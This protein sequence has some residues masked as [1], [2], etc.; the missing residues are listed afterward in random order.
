MK[1]NIINFFLLQ[2]L[3]FSL[4]AAE[5][6]AFSKIDPALLEGAS[7]VK[8]YELVRFE[9]KNAGSAVYYYKTATTIL[10]ENGDEYAGWQEGYDDKFTTIHS[11]NAT[12]YDASGKKIRSLKKAEIK[13]VSGTGGGTLAGD[14]R[15]KHHNFYY[16]IYPYTVEYEVEI[17]KDELMFMPSWTPVKNEG[18]AVENSTFE[19]VCPSGYQIRYK[20]FNYKK[21]P[22]VTGEKDKIY[23]WEV[24]NLPCVEKEFASPA[25]DE[26]TP[27]VYVAPTEFEVQGY[28]GIMNSWLN[29]GKFQSELNK[30]RDKLPEN[31]KTKVHELTDTVTD[32]K[33]KISI[34]YQYMQKNTRYISI[35][36]G[37]G[38][39]Q[40]LEASFVADKGYGDCK[41]LSNFMHS[42]LK[43]AGINSYYCL[44]KAGNNNNFYLPDFP[45]RQSNHA[46]VSV[47]LEKDTVWLECTS[48][49]LPAGYLSG[50]TSNRYALMI[51]D[52][53]GY[54]VHTP[55]YSYKDNLLIRKINATLDEGGNLV[56]DIATSYT[57]MQQDGLFN[58]INTYS[59]K[60]QLDFLKKDIELPSYDIKSF[61]YKT[62]LKQIPEIEE[63]LSVEAHDYAQVSGKRIFIQPNLL[64]KTALEFSD[65]ERINDIELKMGFSDQDSVA[66]KV[67]SGFAVEA[68]PSGVNLQN[69]FGQY[70]ISYK[71]EDN[72]IM[73]TRLFER[74]AGRFPA[75]DYKELLKMYGDMYKA[76]RG[77]IVL[78]KKDGIAAN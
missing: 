62:Y 54:L 48:Q 36:L 23:R 61:D 18:Y 14:G 1:K 29:F 68:L 69:K 10:N 56:A 30:N 35:Q 2:L 22:V 25:W 42:L 26:I 21:E 3:S 41:A 46:L 70:K 77:K 38:G 16:K 66:I 32:V 39:W 51:K 12:L 5:D 60:E 57:G 50:F 9:I 58:I 27:T 11:V 8:R 19:I 78:V 20:A 67:P 17:K 44:I 43:E 28:K 72:Q 59:K 55:D 13:D 76:D 37:I 47:P 34:L 33:R 65:E 63:R 71:V 73:M 40:P 49:Y 31:V 64:N 75:S 15:I 6:Y 7:A 53:G 45:S 52:D 74:K 4:F 24:K